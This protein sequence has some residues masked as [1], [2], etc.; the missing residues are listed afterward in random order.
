M[1]NLINTE[2]IKSYMKENNLS[3]AKFCK[4]CKISPSTFNKIM[5]NGNFKLIA[6]FKI[7]RVLNVY[8][9]QLFYWLLHTK[10]KGRFEA[11]EVFSYM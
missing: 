11:S 8:V 10:W 2:L 5:N 4:I 6:L 1:D 3:K 9:H 7:A